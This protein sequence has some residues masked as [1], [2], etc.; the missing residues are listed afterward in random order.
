MVSSRYRLHQLH[1]VSTIRSYV[2]TGQL[3]GHSGQCKKQ[4]KIDGTLRARQ[5][6]QLLA[7]RIA[8]D[9]CARGVSLSPAD[10]LCKIGALIC[11]SCQLPT[12]YDQEAQLCCLCMLQDSWSSEAGDAPRMEWASANVTAARFEAVRSN[13]GHC[14][15]SLLLRCWLPHAPPGYL[16]SHLAVFS[17]NTPFSMHIP[18]REMHCTAGVSAGSDNCSCT[19]RFFADSKHMS[20][21]EHQPLV[22]DH[23]LIT[24]DES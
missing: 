21:F 4:L 24:Y 1:I 16:S 23:P 6:V 22:L 8:D 7:F 12:A 13:N 2:V 11:A 19:S 17:V 14:Q 3:A 18:Y 10:L 20:V 9:C 15:A 5:T